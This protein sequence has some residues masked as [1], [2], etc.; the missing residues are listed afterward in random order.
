MIKKY[1]KCFN[2]GMTKNDMCISLF[3]SLVLIYPLNI[4]QNKDMVS[5]K[6]ILGG[7]TLAGYDIHNVISMFWEILILFAITFIVITTILGIFANKL[8]TSVHWKD[9]EI[10]KKLNF[11]GII[12]V[13][14][15]S[16]NYIGK[17]TDH[18]T[19]LY[20]EVY[21]IFIFLTLIIGYIIFSPKKSLLFNDFKWTFFI[22]LSLYLTGIMLHLPMNIYMF[23]I[24]FVLF[25]MYILLLKAKKKNLDIMKSV[26]IPVSYLGF[27]L[28]LCSEFYIILNQNKIFISSPK[29]LYLFA[30]VII[31]A[32]CCIR[33]FKYK[34][35]THMKSWENG[36]YLGTLL[37][38]SF[39]IGLS[40]VTMQVN[41]DFFEQ[42]NKAVPISQFYL[43]GKLPIIET[44]SAHMLSDSIFG[45]VYKLLNRDLF[46]SYFGLYNSYA[47]TFNI[48]IFYYLLK[49]FFKA[50]TAI[51]I[52]L[53]F[54]YF[55]GSTMLWS[56]I[57]FLSIL[58]LIHVFE[59]RSK[60]S[61][62]LFWCSLVLSILY[63]GD[64]G[65]AVA[66][67]CLFSLGIMSFFWKKVINYKNLFISLTIVVISCLFIYAGICIM[68]NINPITRACEFISIMGKSN[69]NWAYP[70]IGNPAEITYPLLYIFIPLAMVLVLI[71]LL[72]TLVI[73]NI[74]LKKNYKQY[75]ILLVFI[76]AFFTNLQRPLVRHSL[77][78]S[79]SEII[80]LMFTSVLAI[81]LYLSVNYKKSATIFV[82]SFAVII[83]TLQ[84]ISAKKDINMLSVFDV[85]DKKA[86]GADGLARGLGNKRIDR[87][88]VNPQMFDFYND[89]TNE[90][91]T[92]LDK[93]ETYLDFSNQTFLYSITQRENPVYVN[94]SPGLLM[95]EYTQKLFIEEIEKS[96]K[97]VPIALLA[98]KPI[99][100]GLSID[101]LLNSFRYYKVA[102]YIY[103]NY[104]PI[105]QVG[106]FAIWY[107][108]DREDIKN[109]ILSKSQKLNI[110]SELIGKLKER[111]TVLNLEKDKLLFHT[112]LDSGIENFE[113]IIPADS[114]NEIQASLTIDSN[115]EG[116]MQLYYSDDTV[117]NFTEAKS[118]LYPLKKG[119]QTIQMKVPYNKDMKLRLDFP[120]NGIFK[121]SEITFGNS[122]ISYNYGDFNEIHNYQLGEIP[123][124]WA[125]GDVKKAINDKVEM[126]LGVGNENTYQFDSTKI[127]KDKGNYVKL[128]LN[129]PIDQL[130]QVELGDSKSHEYTR[131]A[132]FSFNVKKG[133]HP[134]LI[135]ISADSGWIPNL[136]NTITINA[137]KT[138]IEQL[139]I[140]KGD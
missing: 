14:L 17:Y 51:I 54:P 55:L 43:Y 140:L 71:K 105:E 50:D 81:P 36:F 25:L 21:M 38:F 59:K 53:F 73:K 113:N 31:I 44:Q 99:S 109:K 64:I 30:F 130:I 88:T 13:I 1:F 104:I 2:L 89:I 6:R 15:I 123:Y 136:F 66:V 35:A 110:N 97:K 49:K 101:G 65:I 24:I 75:L 68:K 3:L 116:S 120:D 26:S 107:K 10:H 63:S 131:G 23:F 18:A 29:L 76:I 79:S 72:S 108:K 84:G 41:T 34:N 124:L 69:Q 61:Y 62:Y 100:L 52:T 129:S 11:V 67:G 33:M 134:Y 133:V 4:F 9:E 46:G 82:L 132:N 19:G 128:V 57:C 92:L 80:A 83:V 102:E 45:L 47:N 138:K 118:I 127:A 115:I 114:A 20:S 77:Y 32:I 27:A 78:E 112:K 87:T 5:F 119:I 85:A 70:S 137:S 94:Q 117:A 91:N 111:N 58:A 86:K 56:S 103:Q 7:A 22:T 96:S 42:A 8:S 37:S 12:G 125:N 28:C 98:A 93:N 122:I 139:E 90:I 121:I 95:D 39:L 74:D 126:K 135:R 48:I 106:D 60:A 16:Y 40:L